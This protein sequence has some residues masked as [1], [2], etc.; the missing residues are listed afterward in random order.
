L[1]GGL[2]QQALLRVHDEGLAGRDAEEVRVELADAGQ[3]TARAGRTAPGQ[4]PEIPAAVSREVPDRVAPVG[5]QAPEVVRGRHAAGDP[6]ADAHY[7]DRFGRVRFGRVRLGRGCRGGRY[8]RRVGA[9][10]GQLGQLG[11]QVY[12]EVA[13]GR[14]VEHQRRGQP[15]P[16]RGGEPG[17]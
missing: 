15:Q 1:P 10:A 9:V 11:Q 13:R 4:R 14:V 17:A 6:A 2:Q 3:E 16:G 5:E 12:G 7:R 8:R